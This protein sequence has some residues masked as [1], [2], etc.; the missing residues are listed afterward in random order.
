MSEPLYTVSTAVTLSQYQ[1]YNRTVQRI[2]GRMQYRIWGMV[3][4]DVIIGI[5]FAYM[6]RQWLVAPFFFVLGGIYAW[7]TVRNLRKAEFAQ[8]QEEQLAGTITYRFGPD[9]LTITTHDNSSTHFYKDAI[10]ALESGSAFYI[11]FTKS[12]GII[13]PKE[14]TTPDLDDFIRKTFPTKNI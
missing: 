5:L 4:L 14:D 2:Y 13:L 7:S 9:F 8:Y 10:E 11:M 6:Y 1:A 12:I 3:A